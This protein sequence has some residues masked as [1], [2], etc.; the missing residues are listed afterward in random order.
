MKAKTMNDLDYHVYKIRKALKK[1]G[2]KERGHKLKVK[3]KRNGRYQL[4]NF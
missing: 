1:E 3:L 4:Y 2:L